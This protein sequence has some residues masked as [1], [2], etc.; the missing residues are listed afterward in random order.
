MTVQ[1]TMTFKETITFK[2][3]MTLQETTTFKENVTLQENTAFKEY[4]TSGNH[5]FEGNK[6]TSKETMTLENHDI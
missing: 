3:N 4:I 2:K 1:E 6:E 5:Y